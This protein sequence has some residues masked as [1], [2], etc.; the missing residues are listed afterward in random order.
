MALTP[1]YPKFRSHRPRPSPPRPVPPEDN[2][3]PMGPR[4]RKGLLPEKIFYTVQKNEL[5]QGMQ[6]SALMLPALTGG[7]PASGPEATRPGLP[8]RKKGQWQ[9]GPDP[10]P[11]P[12]G[13]GGFMLDAVVVPNRRD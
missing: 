12:A 2:R 13:D 7:T 3:P 1:P 8:A 9:G 6:G 10:T 4:S 11:P 5:S